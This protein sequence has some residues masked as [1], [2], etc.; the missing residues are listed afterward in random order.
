MQLTAVFV[1]TTEGYHAFVEELEGATTRGTTLSE[2][3]ARLQQVVTE[4][5][6]Q[7][8][9]LAAGTLTLSNLPYVKEPLVLAVL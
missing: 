8:R 4:L 7:N 9:D 5:I 3:R 6:E 2:T 1:E